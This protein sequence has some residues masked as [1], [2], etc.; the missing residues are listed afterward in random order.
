MP[1]PTLNSA[2]AQIAA[3]SGGL[4]QFYVTRHSEYSGLCERAE[5]GD[6]EAGIVAAL[7]TRIAVSASVTGGLGE[8][9]LCDRP[10]HF[11]GSGGVA[12]VGGSPFQPG[13]TCVFRMLCLPCCGVTDGELM[14]AVTERWKL[15]VTPTLRVLPPAHEAGRA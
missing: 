4:L 3:S 12:L 9:L 13:A 8:C 6:Y 14:R 2:L 15:V 10:C 5:D 11:L 1:D 7:M